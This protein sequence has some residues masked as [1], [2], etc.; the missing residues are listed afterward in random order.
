[1][2]E[3]DNFIRGDYKECAQLIL[4]ITGKSNGEKWFRP[5]AIHHAR[6]MATIIYSLKMYAFSLQI[7]Y[8]DLE[9]KNLEKVVIFAILYIVPWLKCNDATEAALCDLNFYQNLQFFT[10]NIDR[11]AGERA[12]KIFEGQSWYLAEELIPFAL[13]SDSIAKEEKIII[14][15]EI[16][17]HHKKDLSKT[18]EKKGK[19]ILPIVKKNTKLVNLVGC[20]SWFFFSSLNSEGEWL[21]KTVDEWPNDPNYKKLHDFSKNVKV[22]NDTA[23]RWV[24]LIQDYMNFVKDE[25]MKQDLIQAIEQHRSMLKDFDK[26]SLIDFLN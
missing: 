18:F 21:Q 5:G 23:E 12:L 22:V 9:I 7:R 2:L 4:Q 3:K 25:N 26:K 8:T 14:A 15:A 10:E 16:V 13:F 20:R 1:M 11:Q 24:K 6:W 19:P 17:K